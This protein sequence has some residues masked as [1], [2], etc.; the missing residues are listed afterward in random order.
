MKYTLTIF[1]FIYFTGCSL[2]ESDYFSQNKKKKLIIK[3]KNTI[4]YNENESFN[5]FVNSLLKK[6]QN[7]GLPDINNFPE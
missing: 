7:M 4:T 3:K 5:E 6:N 1:T 2:Y